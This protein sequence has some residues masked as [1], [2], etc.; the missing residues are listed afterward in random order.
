MYLLKLLLETTKQIPL[1]TY[2][3]STSTSKQT[4]SST[5]F[6]KFQVLTLLKTKAP[7]IFTSLSNTH[8]G[9][10]LSVTDN[11]ISVMQQTD[12]TSFLLP[13]HAL[14][15][16]PLGPDSSTDSH[17]PCWKQTTY[18]TSLL[19]SPTCFS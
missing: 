8:L 3:R 12:T 15:L 6:V 7:Q 11:T 18:K 14:P 4:Y 9:S 10:C 1:Q 13:P 17:C 16:V 19:F 5:R 2:Y